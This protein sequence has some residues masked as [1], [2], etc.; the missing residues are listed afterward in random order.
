MPMSDQDLIDDIARSYTDRV[1]DL[2]RAAILGT[3]WNE[4]DVLRI[5][6]R[7]PNALPFEPGRRSSTEPEYEIERYDSR[8]PPIT[9]HDDGRAAEVVTVT[10][11]LLER[12]AEANDDI[13]EL[14]QLATP[15]TRSRS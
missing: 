2:Y 10:W 1:E 7:R 12:L 8:A 14:I 5:V 13:D 4:T 11:P 6:A 15:P 9:D 3:D